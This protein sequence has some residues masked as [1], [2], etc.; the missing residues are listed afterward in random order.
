MY[1]CTGSIEEPQLVQRV[2]YI[3]LR[4]TSALFFA[5]P[6]IRDDPEQW[7]AMLR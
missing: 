2:F 4:G 1:P 5:L 6:E 7:A 3:V